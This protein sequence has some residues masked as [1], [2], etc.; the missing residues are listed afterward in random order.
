[1][2]RYATIELRGYGDYHALDYLNTLWRHWNKVLKPDDHR[3]TVGFPSL[4][5]IA[6][7]FSAW[8]LGFGVNEI[9]VSLVSD[10]RPSR[11]ILCHRSMS[12]P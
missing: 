8:E 1:M 11:K 12:H 6:L 7:D 2:I 9:N 10:C 4:L 3:D 5:G